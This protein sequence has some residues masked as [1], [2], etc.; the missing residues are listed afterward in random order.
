MRPPALVRAAVGGRT[1]L[2]S[3]I[4]SDLDPQTPGRL[5]V[6]RHGATAW[7]MAGRHTGRTDPRLTQA[8]EEE[9]R[10][11]NGRLVEFKPAAVFSSPLRRALETSR[12]AG[13]GDDVVVDDRL[14]EW[15][16]GDYEG[17]TF[18]EIQDR[19]PGWRLC[20]DGAPS[21]ESAADVGKRADS[22]LGT[23]RRDVLLYGREVLVFAHGHLLC[24]LA[25]RWLGLPPNM[26]RLLVLDSSGIGVL[27]WKRSEPVVERWN[28]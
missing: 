25:V 22:F 11:L 14:V 6:V 28:C 12:L 16:Y 18:S 26:A 8:G 13:F 2:D 3:V 15:D 10:T 1:T 27:G 5:I 17:L 7:S 4:K 21:G 20:D 24:V 9:A 19:S 23:L